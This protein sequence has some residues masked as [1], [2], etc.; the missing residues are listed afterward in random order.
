MDLHSKRYQ[1]VYEAAMLLAPLRRDVGDSRFGLV[2]QAL[3]AHVLLRLGGRIVDIKNQGHPDIIAVLGGQIYHIEVEAPRKTTV[4]RQLDP[5]DLK[6]LRVSHEGR[7]GYF[8]VLDSGPPLNWVCV[9][10]AS[11]G[12][13]VT[14]KLRV[15]LLKSRADRDLSTAC[16]VEFS[17]LVIRQSTVLHQ[18][19]F[20]QLRE[21]ALGSK[22]R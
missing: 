5:G 21:E 15:S 10:V 2:V 6:V 18:L 22:P 9:D 19:T 4:P 13:R 20:N 7:R 14:G 11:L 1:L 17:N 12:R 16:S 3:F 8:C